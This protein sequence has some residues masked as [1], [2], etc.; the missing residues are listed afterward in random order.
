MVAT[1]AQLDAGVSVTDAGV[2]V[3]TVYC[4]V[5]GEKKLVRLDPRAMSPLAPTTAIVVLA[6][7]GHTTARWNGITAARPP[8]PF[9]VSTIEAT[10]RK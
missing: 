9:F 10:P 8:P 2:S 7:V 1:V 4:P 6:A 5:S 3:T